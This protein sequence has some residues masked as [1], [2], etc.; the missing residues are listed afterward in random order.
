MQTHKTQGMVTKTL[1]FLKLAGSKCSARQN[2]QSVLGRALCVP[3]LWFLTEFSSASVQDPKG[4][5]PQV[6][7]FKS[8]NISNSH[9]LIMI[10]VKQHTH[11]VQ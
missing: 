2:N 6:M 7:R 3:T 11:A 10:I 1:N 5:S 9:F 8:L 4:Y